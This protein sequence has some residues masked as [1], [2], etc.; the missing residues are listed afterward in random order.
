MNYFTKYRILIGVVILL[1]AINIAI[2]ATLGFHHITPKETQTPPPEAEQQ[3]IR[4][5]REL[6]LT[7]EQNKMY[8]NL[9]QTYFMQTQENRIA[10]Q[11]NYGQIMNELS[12][13]N[14]DTVLLNSLAL[15]IGKLH[16]EQQHATIDHF[17]T[18]QS[19]C[20]EEQYKRLQQHFK[21]R[22]NPEFGHRR[23]LMHRN[24]RFNRANRPDSGN[25]NQ[26]D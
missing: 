24:R 20:S 6:N 3:G 16:V 4:I 18:L 8:H 19:I 2:L 10:L 21:R 7:P 5:A 12:S 26:M 11:Q 14:P 13:P 25:Y 15:Q 23:G 1:A 22:M 17:L 9:R